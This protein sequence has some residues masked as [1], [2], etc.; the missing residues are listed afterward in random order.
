MFK[1]FYI[2]FGEHK[3]DFFSITEE[4]KVLVN[5]VDDD[6]WEADYEIT[7]SLIDGVESWD[8]PCL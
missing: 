6:V 2:I 1:S 7:G 3:T 4:T 5:T 8:W